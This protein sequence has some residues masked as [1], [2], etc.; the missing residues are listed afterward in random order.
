MSSSPAP[1]RT[2]D[3]SRPAAG[4]V[5]HGTGSALLSSGV[6]TSRARVAGCAC[7]YRAAAPATC[8]EAI[9]VPLSTAA[10]P[11]STGHV[12]RIRP[13]G[14][15][16]SGFS[17]RSAAS[18]SEENDDIRPPPGIGTSTVGAQVRC[19]GP[20]VEPCVDQLAF[21]AADV[22]GRDRDVRDVDRD[23][24]GPDVVV[25]H[26]RHGAR[27][28][29]VEALD[30]EKADTAPDE[31]DLAFEAPGGQRRARVI[32]GGRP[33]RSGRVRTSRPSESGSARCPR[34][35]EPAAGP[36]RS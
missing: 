4:S 23:F 25:D 14:A 33:F 35:T 31:R 2:T 8:G 29:D 12:E 36:A 20:C 21:G 28:G 13:P 22:H 30:V 1:C 9:E 19:T 24:G 3:S 26:D 18:P 7:R 15:A 27:G 17:D 34:R 11:F 6:A 16:T 5:D 32:R 10:P